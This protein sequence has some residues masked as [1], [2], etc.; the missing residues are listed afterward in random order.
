MSD[1]YLL[2]GQAAQS[3][4]PF[5]RFSLLS[6]AV[7][8]AD[9]QNDEEA[10]Y[11]TRDELLDA[12]QE[13]GDSQ[14]MLLT[15]GWMINYADNNPE[16]VSL[17]DLLWR[18]K[19]ALAVS[20]FLPS[21]PLQRIQA[22]QDDF[23]RRLQAVGQSTRTADGDRWRL[24]LHCG[25]LETA[26]QLREQ[27]TKTKSGYLDCDACDVDLKVT[28]LLEMGDLDGAMKAGLSVFSGKKSCNRIPARTHAAVLLP[29]FKAGRL[30]EAEKHHKAGYRKVRGDVDSLRE[31]AQ[32]LLYLALSGQAKAARKVHD[33]HLQ[34]AENNRTPLDLLE[35]HLCCAAAEVA[36]GEAFQPEGGPN[37]AELARE[38]AAR[39]D[40]RN[41]TN[42]H[43]DRLQ[44]MLSL[45]F[46]NKDN[47]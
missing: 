13:I 19:W 22:L 29:L 47:A 35:W 36:L 16:E 10:G 12:A 3:N 41:S 43:S 6:E 26:E 20:R 1:P 42:Y 44:E 38:L 17:W 4:D 5:E 2:M 8:L 7:R 45:D 46:S 28:H 18:Y 39:F 21:V 14:T 31:Q 24:A 30:E 34:F 15:F 9:L 33:D 25:D 32:H 27:F 23:A 11:E 40:A 37:H